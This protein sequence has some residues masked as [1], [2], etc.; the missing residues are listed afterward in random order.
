VREKTAVKLPEYARKPAP[1]LGHLLLFLLSR[2]LLGNQLEP[3]GLHLGGQRRFSPLALG[4]FSRSLALLP[5]CLALSGGLCH[6][7]RVVTLATLSR[8]GRRVLFLLTSPPFGFPFL[9]PLRCC[10]RCR[11][12]CRCRRCCRRSRRSSL[13]R[14]NAI[15]FGSL[16]SGSLLGPT[17][18]L[19]PSPPRRELLGGGVVDGTPLLLL[20]AARSCLG[21][22]LRIRRRH[23]VGLHRFFVVRRLRCLRA[24]G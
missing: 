23:Q 4:R 16:P 15:R 13:L 3:F 17:V 14:C 24:G 1:T 9:I 11:C 19:F 6:S 18:L 7:C 22:R 8:S 5:N 20:A 21:F 10:R 12:R 2:P